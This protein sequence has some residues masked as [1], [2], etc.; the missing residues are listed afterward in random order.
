MEDGNGVLDPE[1]TSS[2]LSKVCNSIKNESEHQSL[3]EAG[4]LQNARPIPHSPDN[5]VAGQK[6]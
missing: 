1:N 6:Y 5:R 4:R 3:D 2:V